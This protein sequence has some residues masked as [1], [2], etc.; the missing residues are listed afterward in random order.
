MVKY[1]LLGVVLVSMFL[2]INRLPEGRPWYWHFRHP[3]HSFRW[4]WDDEDNDST[5]KT[6]SDQNLSVPFDSLAKKGILNLDAAAGNF[7]IKGSTSE[8][9]SFSKSGDIGNYELTTKDINGDKKKRSE[10]QV[11][12]Q[13]GMEPR[14]E[15]R[16]RRRRSRPE[17]LQDRYG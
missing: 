8:F 6:F 5:T 10:H 4:E 3:V 14:H 2:I 11:E 16:R 7:K 15:H 1:I 13:T 12:S 9:L 17:R